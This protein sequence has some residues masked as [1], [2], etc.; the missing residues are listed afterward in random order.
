[1]NNK[2]NYITRVRNHISKN[3][4]LLKVEDILKL[5]KIKLY[6]E[7]IRML[8]PPYVLNWWIT[9]IINMHN[10]NI[11]VIRIWN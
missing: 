5:H 3:R 8:L 4:K 11:R 9:P 10:Y 6:L 1:V 7:Y 2:L